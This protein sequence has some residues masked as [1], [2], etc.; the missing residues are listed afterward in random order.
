MATTIS[1]PAR[2]EQTSSTKTITISDRIHHFFEGQAKN[3]TGWFLLSLM[4]QG[5]FFLPIPAALTYYFG[6][7]SLL[8]IVTLGL[9]FSSVIAGMGG[10]S[11]RS[12]ISLLA[13]S[14]AIH[15][16]MLVIFIV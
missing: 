13:A 11:I 4:V 2:W 5:V 16:L 10:G 9:F 7:P 14:A 15:L 3:R 8:V 6:A 12:I 1:A